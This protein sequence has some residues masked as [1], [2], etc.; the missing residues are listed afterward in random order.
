MESMMQRQRLGAFPL[1]MLAI[2]LGFAA[3]ACGSLPQ[4]PQAAH[5]FSYSVVP[6]K[7]GVTVTV[8]DNRLG[9]HTVWVLLLNPPKGVN[10]ELYRGESGGGAGWASGGTRGPLAAGT[11]Q[12]RRLQRGWH[13]PQRHGAVLDAEVPRWPRPDDGA[14]IAAGQAEG[15][16]QSPSARP[17]KAHD[18]RARQP[19]VNGH[20]RPIGA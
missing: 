3:A 19:G 4:M 14:L 1:I 20:H 5:S 16:A 13:R 7:G 8:A 12:L 9:K 15:R 6:Y 2:A 10:R 18:S 11:V 17:P